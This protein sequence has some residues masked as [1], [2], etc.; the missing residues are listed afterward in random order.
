MRNESP[1]NVFFDKLTIQHSSGPLQEE[2]HYDSLDL[3]LASISAKAA[4]YYKISTSSIMV[5]NYK[6][7]SLA[8]VAV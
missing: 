4:G 8:M 3:E 6:T 7:K 5:W 2:N 1:Q